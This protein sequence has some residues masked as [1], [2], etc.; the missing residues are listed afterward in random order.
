MEGNKQVEAIA[1]AMAQLDL[2]VGSQFAEILARPTRIRRA[3]AL[4]GIRSLR[5]GFW[6]SVSNDVVAVPIWAC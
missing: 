4:A 2:P 3:C 5:N 6:M 1:D